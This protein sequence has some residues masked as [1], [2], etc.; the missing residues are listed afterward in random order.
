MIAE[1][2]WNAVMRERIVAVF[3]TYGAFAKAI[4]TSRQHVV[5]WC[6][7]AVPHIRWRT[8]IVDLLGPIDFPAVDSPKSAAD[9]RLARLSVIQ[10]W[11]AKRGKAVTYSQQK[12]ADYVGISK[13]ALQQSE[14]RAMEKLRDGM[15][16]LFELHSTEELA[17]AMRRFPILRCVYESQRHA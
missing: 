6:S 16:G 3:R 11:M 8:Q 12:I 9:E 17:A 2:P 4:G 15:K 7:G 10:N 14:W 1:K 13:H 5:F